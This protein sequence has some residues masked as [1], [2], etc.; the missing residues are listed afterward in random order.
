MNWKYWPYWVKGGIIGLLV[1]LIPVFL[2]F[3]L[4]PSSSGC[5]V[6]AV[7]GSS[8][9]PAAYVD[10]LWDLFYVASSFFITGGVIGWLYGK[11]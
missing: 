5:N 9:C 11:I 10:V 2:L 7:D 1:F 8:Y 6:S 4:V 3:L